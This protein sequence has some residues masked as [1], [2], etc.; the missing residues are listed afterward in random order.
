MR[1]VVVMVTTSYPRFPGDSVGTFMEPIAKGIAARGHEV[2]VV[3]PWHPLITRGKVEEAAKMLGL[4][5]RALYR[6]LERLDLSDTITRRRD[7]V[8]MAEA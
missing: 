1:H 6:R 8:M 3:A 5:R 7:A 2:H 4:S